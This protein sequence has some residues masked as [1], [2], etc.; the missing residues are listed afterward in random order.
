MTPSPPARTTTKFTSAPVHMAAQTAAPQEGGWEEERRREAATTK[1]LSQNG[2]RSRHSLKLFLIATGPP[3]S[4]CSLHNKQLALLALFFALRAQR[5]NKS[6]GKLTP[7][8]SGNPVPVGG[9]LR[10]GDPLDPPP[11]PERTTTKAHPTT[12]SPTCSSQRRGTAH[13]RGRGVALHTCRASCT[14]V[15]LSRFDR[16]VSLHM[17]SMR[18]EYVSQ[19]PS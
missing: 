15:I 5:R 9:T 11:P 2:D 13:M 19:T 10:P 3:V 14:L 8:Q 17:Q 7:Q 4:R 1:S 16:G 18:G 6:D 12:Y